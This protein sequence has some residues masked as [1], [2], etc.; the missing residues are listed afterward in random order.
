ML[1]IAQVHQLDPAAGQITF[2]LFWTRGRGNCTAAHI[3]V[4][5]YLAL[6]GRTGRFGELSDPC[7]CGDDGVS[8]DL[9]PSAEPP[10]H[11]GVAMTYYDLHGKERVCSTEE[12]A[13][14]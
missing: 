8:T 14:W 2:I 9:W 11:C 10:A 1:H 6:A 7:Y 5:G 13:G 12:C 3:T 4:N